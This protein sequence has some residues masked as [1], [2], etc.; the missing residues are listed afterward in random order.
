MKAYRRTPP[1][2]HAC[3]VLVAMGTVAMTTAATSLHATQTLSATGPPVPAGAPVATT[4]GGQVWGTKLPASA[5]GVEVNQYLG[6]P[7]A[8]AERWSPPQDFTGSYPVSPRNST[9]W[10]PACLQV[11]TE[12]TTYGSEACLVANVWQPANAVPG[13]KKKVLVFVYGGSDQFGEAEPYNMSAL[14]AF[15]DTVTVNF[16]Y[17]TGPIGWM[18]F[19]E[20]VAANKSTGNWGILDI[21]SALRWVEREIHNFG[22][23]PATVAIHGQSSGGGLIELQYVAPDSNYLFNTAISESGGLDATPL[24]DALA[25]TH[26]MARYAGCGNA[27]NIK[28]C[29][30]NLD[31]LT[32]TSMTYTGSWGPTT[33]GVTF[34]DDPSTLLAQGKVNN[35]S[36][37]FGAQTNDSQLFLFRDYT[38]DDDEPQPNDDPTGDLENMTDIKFIEQLVMM[39]GAD[40][41]A[42]AL[43]I[44]KPTHH[45]SVYNVHQLGRVESDQMLCEARRRAKQFDRAR[46][47]RARVYRFNYWYQ[48]NTACTAVPNYHLP[49]LGA[50]HQDEVTFVMG[51]PNFMEQGSCCGLWGLSEGAEGCNKSVSCTACYDTQLGEGYRAYF[52]DKEWDFTRLVGSYWTNSATGNPNGPALPE[53]PNASVGF[54]VLDADVPGGMKVEPHLNGDHR[55]CRLWNKVAESGVGRRRMRK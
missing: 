37:I 38:I 9:M 46:P 25:N 1:L 20:D 36:V 31:P 35:C 27:T 5:G 16:N 44:Y 26:E 52:N 14:A 17:R 6:I 28:E 50:V 39:T 29:M 47:G 7:F 41:L 55:I 45:H 34:P 24:K 13:A 33:D 48:S 18:A 51:Q 53:W 8:T 22:G 10:G 42:E 30:T 12:N 40:Y 4:N 21:Q 49:Y 15:H 2:A 23:N 19:P 11:L 54:A 32:I 43:H 3:R